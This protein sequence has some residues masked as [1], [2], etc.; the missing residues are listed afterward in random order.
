M[1]VSARM[2]TSH[3]SICQNVE[4]AQTGGLPSNRSR[5]ANRFDAMTMSASRPIASG[6][7]NRS[8]NARR[9]LSTSTMT[10]SSE[11][12]AEGARGRVEHVDDVGLLRRREA[13]PARQAE[14][15]V[16]QML[17]HGAAPGR[18]AL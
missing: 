11:G 1:N 3:G 17:G 7:W 15:D 14:P 12:R 16:E 10:R 4:I 6:R 18:A 2:P 9:R 5:N 13:R 8:A